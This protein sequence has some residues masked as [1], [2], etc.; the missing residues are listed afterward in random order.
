M[1]TTLRPRHLLLAAS[2]A[3]TACGTA[4]ADRAPPPQAG[5]LV[6]EPPRSPYEVEL[7]AADGRALST[8]QHRGRYYVMG[9]VGERYTIRVSNPTDRRIEAVISVDGLDAI[10]GQDADYT[11]KRG[12]V[13]PPRGELRVDGFRV[14]TSQVATFRFSSVARSYAGRQGKARNVGVIGVAIFEERAAPE[15][16]VADPSPHRPPHR[17]A[18]RRHYDFDD[19]SVEGELAPPPAAQRG[20]ARGGSTP[21]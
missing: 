7:V 18:P 1:S 14:S 3:A 15:I 12:Y 16:I 21:G 13:V 20:S 2:L 4:F 11:R 8:Y 10:D 6:P 5:A 9:R 17:P 19:S